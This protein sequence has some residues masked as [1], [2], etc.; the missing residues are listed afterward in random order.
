MGKMTIQDIAKRAGVSASTV[1]RVINNSALVN[2]KTAELVHRVIQEFDYQPN[3]LAQ[4]LRRNTTKTIGVIISDILNPFYTSVVRGIEDASNK[5]DYNIILCNTD[6]KPEKEFQYI[7]TLVSKQVDGLI[8][9]S[10]HEII[11]YDALVNSRPLVFIDR[12]PH[13]KNPNRYDLVLVENR[14]GGF[15]AV[16]HLIQQEYQHIGIITGPQELTTAHERLLGYAEAII[17][18]GR[19]VEPELIKIGDFFGNSAYEQALELIRSTPCDAIFAS[20]NLI[21]LGV[22]RAIDETDLKIPE[23]FG[24]IGFD[25]MEWMRYGSRTISAVEQPTYDI[26]ITAAHLLLDRIN[27]SKLPPKEVSL[28][29]RLIPRQSSSRKK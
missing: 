5:H 7:N 9:A 27:G 1:S 10:S 6:G 13:T 28:D 15:E 29:V 12:R 14:N 25:D 24:L 23:Q 22:M 21:L 18:A 20:N 26:G 11:D 8:V 16:K 3:A 19:R 17:T 2:E 4:S